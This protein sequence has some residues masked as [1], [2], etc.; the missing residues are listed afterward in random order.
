MQLPISSHLQERQV[1]EEIKKQ[2]SHSGEGSILHRELGTEPITNRQTREN[3]HLGK[4]SKTRNKSEEQNMTKC[5]GKTTRK[6]DKI[7][8]TPSREP[9]MEITPNAKPSGREQDPPKKGKHI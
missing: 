5:G 9:A 3:A 6:I 8:A 7:T 1:L 4:A 2:I